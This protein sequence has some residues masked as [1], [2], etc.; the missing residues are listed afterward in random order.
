VK[1]GLFGLTVPLTVRN[2]AELCTGKNGI[3]TLS[4]SSLSYKNTMFYSIDDNFAYGGDINQNN[5]QGGESIYGWNFNDEN[6]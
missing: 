5:G 3:S 2:F 4:G 6:F 1:I